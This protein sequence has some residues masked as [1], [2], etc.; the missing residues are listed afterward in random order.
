ME[1]ILHQWF[2]LESTFSNPTRSFVNEGAKFLVY[3]VND[4]W[5]IKPPELAAC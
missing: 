1:L 5:Y 3:I 4:G 2:C